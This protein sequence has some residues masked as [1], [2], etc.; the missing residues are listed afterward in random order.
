MSNDNN[1][2]SLLGSV[3]MGTGVMI[4]AGILALTGQVAE[5]AGPYFPIAFIAGALV[6]AFSAYTY[7][8]LSHIHPSS[9]GVAMFLKQAYGKSLPT[10][11]FALLMLLSMVINQS[12]VAR[13]FGSYTLQLFE[14][15]SLG[16]WAAPILGVVLLAAAFL[17]NIIGNKY[18]ERL[19]IVM[20]FF[21]TIGLL[22]LA[23]GGL[24]AFGFDFSS[25]EF[26][27]QSESSSS[28]NLVVQFIAAVALSI[29]AFKGFTTI[30]NSGDEIR[31]PKVNIGRSIIISLA[32]CLAV[33]L[34]TTM[35]V[36]G[37]LSISEI[38]EAKD[39]ALAEAA[40]PAFG[41][42]GL[43]ITVLFAIIATVSG[44]IASIFAVSRM[45]TMLTK[46]E[47]VPHS[48]FG[49]PGSIQKHSVVYIVVLAM[50]LT[51]S[52]DLSRIASIGAIFYLIMDIA[53][54]Y[55][56]ITKLKDKAELNVSIPIIAII[57]DAIVLLAFAYIKFKSDPL[58]L[59][60]TLG[61][62]ILITLGERLF[63]QQRN[64]K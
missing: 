2:L 20:A 49:M 48:H 44:V 14:F 57:L 3:S 41:Q 9:G 39:Y 58:I 7:I 56:A 50:I 35:A 45:L 1:K 26:S 37:N 16:D 12:L 54:H 40:K 22:L 55:G 59:W 46:M 31:K 38:I 53:I 61:G 42:A 8:K 29:L 15:E 62:L 10:A 19:S 18:I 6:S 24:W 11:V 36:I 34:L 13:T 52:F 32:I 27:G 5:L 28:E 63:L 60:V 51:I 21:K 64:A 25:I 30:T 33:Y 4:G 47:L 23:L 43:T 17:L